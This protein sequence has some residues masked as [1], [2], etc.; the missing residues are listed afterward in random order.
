MIH[1]PGCR[2]GR[3]PT[4]TCVQSRP[5]STKRVGLVLV[6]VALALLGVVLLTWSPR[7]PSGDTRLAAVRGSTPR[8]AAPPASEVRVPVARVRRRDDPETVARWRTLAAAVAA[9]RT[10]R[11]AVLPGGS[12]APGAPADVPLDRDYI[13][14]R[15][16][17]LVDLVRECYELTLA[18]RPAAEGRLVVKFAI[19]SEP[20]VGAVVSSSEIDRDGSSP[21][22]ADDPILADCVRETMY[23]AD[24]AAATAGGTVQVTYPFV[25][26]TAPGDA[27][28]RRP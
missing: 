7:A 16:R 4:V 24:F 12:D 13:R 6:L 28:P 22:L 27:G 1:G 23:T 25:F 26:S 19:E 11:R 20:G 15:V 8:T 5:V 14:A 3:A 10:R 17:D 2:G 18:E 21:A 9:A